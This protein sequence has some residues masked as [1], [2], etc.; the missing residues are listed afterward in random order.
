M[1]FVSSI[2][3]DEELSPR[4]G[5]TLFGRERELALLR[6]VFDDA[7]VGHGSALVIR[8]VTGIGKTAILR[9]G[10]GEAERR[11]FIILTAAGVESE[12]S[13]P[14]G[15]LHQL[16]GRLLAESSGLAPAQR[17]MM[18][19][20]FGLE[21]GHPDLYAV[22]LAALELVVDTAAASPVALLIDDMHWFDV[23]SSDVL[24]FIARR[25]SGDA[26][27]IIGATRTIDPT[28]RCGAPDCPRPT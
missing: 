16:L 7:V 6:G 5:E 25:I 12:T 24:A 28:I 26:V 13:L 3:G 10:Q 9:A 11:G 15:I 18:R 1:I 14:F 20:A 27:V 17:G 8:G 19:A 23:A 4:P 2:V 21:E 22:A